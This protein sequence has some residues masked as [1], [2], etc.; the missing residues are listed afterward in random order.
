M[1]LCLIYTAGRSGK[2]STVS[3]W[4]W[5]E[6]VKLQRLPSMTY[7]LQQ[8]P[9]TPTRVYVAT[10]PLAMG[11]GGPFHANHLLYLRIIEIAEGKESQLN[12]PENILNKIIKDNFPKLKEMPIW[13]THIHC[14]WQKS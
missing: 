9:P 10:V 8:G 11:I 5:L 14:K 12:V 6:H 13:L 1:S 3:R 4:A 7:F 2:S